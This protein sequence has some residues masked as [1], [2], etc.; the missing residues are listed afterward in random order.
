M[1]KKQREKENQKVNKRRKDVTKECWRLSLTN[2]LTEIL[3]GKP[4]Q[5]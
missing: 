2:P 5:F 3:G 4:L 1:G